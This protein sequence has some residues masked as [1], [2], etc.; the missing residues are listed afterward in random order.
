MTERYSAQSR[1]QSNHGWARF[2]AHLEDAFRFPKGRGVR[3]VRP[4]YPRKVAG[5]CSGL[6]DHFGWDVTLLRVLAV[7]L[8]AASTGLM[9]VAYAVAWVLNP[10][11]PY[12]LPSGSSRHAGTSAS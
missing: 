11:G 8:T 9:I 3:L 10:E 4:R 2:V 12:S 5:V 1:T 6:A 7:V